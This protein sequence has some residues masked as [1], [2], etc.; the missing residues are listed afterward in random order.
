MNSRSKA[1][2]AFSILLFVFLIQ[3]GPAS[4]TTLGEA[5][6]EIALKSSAGEDFTLSSLKG[7]SGAVV[8]FFATWCPACMGEV[9]ELIEFEKKHGKSVPV[10][11]VNVREQARI[12]ERFIKR[13]QVNYTVLL[14]SAGAV[15]GKYKVQG[16]PLILGI[17]KQGIIRYSAHSL[18]EDLNAFVKQLS[19]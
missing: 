7:K 19:E 9:P 1:V 16:I 5:A 17:D 15:T 18:P 6:P 11:A 10:Y 4:A 3:C 2:A 8:V 13:K 12:V 14:D